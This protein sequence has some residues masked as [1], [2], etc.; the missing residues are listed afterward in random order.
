M[1]MRI[2]ILCNDRIG[3]PAIRR[4][5]SSYNVVGAGIPWRR[6]DMQLLLQ[7][8]CGRTN[9][10][11]TVF[12][13]T[14]FTNRLL[15][16]LHD[17]K[18]D[19]VLVKTFPWRIPEE[20]LHIPKHGFINFHYAPLPVWRGPNPLFWMIRKQVATGGITIH[21]MDAQYDNGPILLQQQMPLSP[22]MTY[23]LLCTQLAYAGLHQSEILLKGLATGSIK[24][25]SQDTSQAKWFPRPVPADLTI[26][27]NTMKAE[28][29]K[30]LVNAC[31][32]WNKGA[33]TS[34]KGWHFG[35]TE[36]TVV[37]NGINKNGVLPGTIIDMNEDG[38]MIAC[39][40]EKAIKASVVYCEE[41]FFTGNK[42]SLFGLKAAE[43]LGI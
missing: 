38:L 30:A 40:E 25:Q 27:W 39:A 21:K 42:L 15:Q 32:P 43:R 22:Q 16:W 12:R 1:N 37:N 10:P 4:L 8:Q 34:W 35:I 9:V 28:E 7:Q 31:N 24:E 23:G 6:A 3:L 17:S 13:K 11:C 26:D 29:I 36:A 5:V 2:A 14:E 20:A 41:G 33:A 19:V 18:P